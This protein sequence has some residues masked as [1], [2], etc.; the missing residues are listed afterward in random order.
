MRRT[1]PPRPA[2]P[3]PVPPPSPSRA[4]D[5]A[6]RWQGAPPRTAGGCAGRASL[7]GEEETRETAEEV[8][9]ALGAKVSKLYRCLIAGRS[10]S[11]LATLAAQGA[12]DSHGGRMLLAG[13][14]GKAPAT[15]VRR[16]LWP[17][18]GTLVA[19]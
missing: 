5:T 15:R 19:Q 9:V 3:R 14:F 2:P 12:E 17:G 6:P 11:P 18:A 8:A 7:G 1:S 13:D 4:P 10:P 16:P